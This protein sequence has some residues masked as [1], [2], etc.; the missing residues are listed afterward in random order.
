MKV[1]DYEPQFWFFLTDGNDYFIDINCSYSFIGFSRLIKL[2]Q[3]EKNEY[4]QKGKEYLNLLA[5]DIQYYALSKYKERNIIGE[6]EKQIQNA[7][8]E[9]NK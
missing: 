9:F 2:N 8:I 4:K 5:N 3:E 1:I 7:I 6:L